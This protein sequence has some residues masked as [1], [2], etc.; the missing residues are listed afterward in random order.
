MNN[1]SKLIFEN[2]EKQQIKAE[3]AELR[4]KMKQL[5]HRF[6]NARGAGDSINTHKGQMEVARRIAEL[7]AKLV[8]EAVE[9]NN[10]QVRFILY[11]N[12]SG[13][14]YG[15]SNAETIDKAWD[16]VKHH[17][18]RYESGDADQISLQV[19]SEDKLDGFWVLNAPGSLEGEYILIDTQSKNEA[20]Q[21]EIT[22]LNLIKYAKEH[23]EHQK[24]VRAD[25]LRVF[26]NGAA[27]KPCPKCDKGHPYGQ[28]PWMFT[29]DGD[30]IV[31]HDCGYTEPWQPDF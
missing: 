17:V 25:T 30:K 5:N 12:G 4:K 8:Q 24:E 21:K 1:D 28:N 15:V 7:R 14:V 6:K 13:N 31:C 18:A 29:K 27:A 20:V 2:Y 3:I 26:G 16:E 9:S 11:G 10:P 23:A 19:K 22:T